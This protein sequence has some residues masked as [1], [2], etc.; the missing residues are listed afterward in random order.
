VIAVL[1]GV[2]IGRLRGGRLV[3]L[4]RLAP[5]WLPLLVLAVASVTAARAALVPVGTARV[6]VILG[7][8]LALI[9]LA[10][11]LTLPWLWL[12]LAGAAL[13]AIVIAANAGRMPVSGA[14]I[15][16]ISRSLI[17]GGATGPFYVL[18]GPRTALAPL[19]DTLPL[20]VGG[21]G[22]VL[23]PGDLLLALGIAATLQAGMLSGRTSPESENVDLPRGNGDRPGPGDR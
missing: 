19:G 2:A 3:N 23:S 11:N 13:N 9:G 4:T 18:A 10:A 5:R 7:Y 6:L 14:V 21:V 8:L 16:V 15:R 22:V 12:A 1:A 20:V 17:F